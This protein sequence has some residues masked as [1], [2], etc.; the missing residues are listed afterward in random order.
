MEKT[1]KGFWVVLVVSMFPM[2]GAGCISVGSG[3]GIPGLSGDNVPKINMAAVASRPN[4]P[5][6]VNDEQVIVD[7]IKAHEKYWNKGDVRS[8]II[9]YASNAQIMAG[10]GGNMVS[11]DEYEKTFLARR[12]RTG[13]VEYSSIKVVNIS[14]TSASAKYTMWPSSARGILNIQV[15]LD[16]K[17][18]D[19]EWLITKQI[20]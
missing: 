17:K 2:M 11:R 3:I 19:G 13:D 16:L 7:L 6:V 8:L 4:A 14:G 9:V 18:E 1:R 5:R 10:Q 12:D 20:Y 15:K